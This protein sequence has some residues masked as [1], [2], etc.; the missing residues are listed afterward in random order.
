M[1]LSLARTN[2]RTKFYDAVADPGKGPGSPL[3]LDQTGARR[4]K[5]GFFFDTSPPPLFQGLYDRPPPS[6]HPAS[7][8]LDPP[9]RRGFTVSSHLSVC[10]K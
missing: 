5:K 4:A 9:L 3:S 8:G 2:L 1:L 7:E 10:V 6:L